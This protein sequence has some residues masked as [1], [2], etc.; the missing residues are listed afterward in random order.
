MQNKKTT[1]FS[2]D[3]RIEQDIIK[4]KVYEEDALTD[5]VERFFGSLTLKPSSKDKLKGKL[6][7]QF[8]KLLQKKELSQVIKNK[9]ESLLDESKIFIMAIDMDKNDPSPNETPFKILQESVMNGRK[10]SQ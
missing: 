5:I 7:E 9:L 6:E 1:L 3:L 2:L 4:L 10:A 8:K